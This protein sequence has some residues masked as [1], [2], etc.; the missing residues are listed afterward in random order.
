MS[1]KS[2]WF[3]VRL[4]LCK[5]GCYLRRDQRREPMRKDH[6]LILGQM[7]PQDSSLPTTS[8]RYLDL[9]REFHCPGHLDE[10][11]PPEDKWAA[12]QNSR[13]TRLLRS[14]TAVRE[15]HHAQL[16]THLQPGSSAHNTHTS[17][18]S[19]GLFR[20]SRWQVT[21]GS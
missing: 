20:S 5:P 7:N 11:L 1:N 3:V 17:A 14:R 8:R 2:R 13:Q 6:P 18:S 19:D 15:A 16:T 4:Q 21:G 10:G 9:L 12:E